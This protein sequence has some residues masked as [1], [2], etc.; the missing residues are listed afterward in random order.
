MMSPSSFACVHDSAGKPLPTLDFLQWPLNDLAPGC[1]AVCA[2]LASARSLVS[3]LFWS[4]RVARRR[5]LNHDYYSIAPPLTTT[6]PPPLPKR[7]TQEHWRPPSQVAH[8][9]LGYCRLKSHE[10]G[11][12]YWWPA[13]LSPTSPPPPPP[14]RARMRLPPRE[15]ESMYI[16]CRALRPCMDRYQSMFNKNPIHRP[17][18][19]HHR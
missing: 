14:R 3:A 17:S 5:S 19:H 11:R 16:P 7:N 4:A 18:I 9:R 15:S 13:P 8:G 10:S 2:A 12:A 1:A 6:R